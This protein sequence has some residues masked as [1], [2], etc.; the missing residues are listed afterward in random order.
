MN[1]ATTVK[2]PFVT[3]PGKGS[4]LLNVLETLDAAGI[5]YCISHGYETV[6][7]DNQTDIDLYIAADQTPARI[8]DLLHRNRS[9]I[10]A[11]IVRKDGGR[12]VLARGTPERKL[13]PE[14]L[15]LSFAKT[16]EARGQYFYS[17]AEIVA[18]RRKSGIF[19][20]PAVPHEF[21]G[22][23]TR[24]IA[25]G[26]LDE[27]RVEKLQA[28]FDMAPQNCVH[29]IRRFWDVRQSGLISEAALAKNWTPV[30]LRGKELQSE[31]RLR[32][33][34]GNPLHFARSAAHAVWL[35]V[36]NFR[37]PGGLSIALIG[38]AGAGRTA[39]LQGVHTSLSPLFANILRTSIAGSTHGGISSAYGRTHDT[40]V[41]HPLASLLA[42]SFRF[43]KGIF[44]YPALQWSKSRSCLI[45]EDGH[46]ADLLASSANDHNGGPMSLLRRMWRFL[47]KPE[48]LV[49][50]DSIPE[51]ARLSSREIATTQRNAYL[52]LAK[53][54]ETG[55]I[56]DASRPSNLVTED[57]SAAILHFMARRETERLKL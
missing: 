10:G 53:I 24:W 4:I 28:L 27:S 54:F 48:M 12:I 34:Q 46:F 17:G 2:N 19:W 18:A 37:N 5:A 50:L 38:P 42:A 39:I 6:P 51:F 3:I 9:V 15:T 44:T 25:R 23:L 43:C 41:A 1:I 31:L 57:I 49:F 56:V 20:V 55:R 26:E 47:P 36:R 7:D 14:F 52:S 33:L 29:E 16:C 11:T 32:R 30:L 8:S 35:A 13:L 45:L 22:N 21:A 40:G